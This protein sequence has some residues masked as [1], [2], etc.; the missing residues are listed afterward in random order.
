M[1]TIRVEE[2]TAQCE[3]NVTVLRSL[4]LLLVLTTNLFTRVRH[5][6]Y[7]LHYRSGFGS[8]SSIV[9]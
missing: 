8:N 9:Y 3:L 5:N 6:E 4:I 1:L 2:T 7:L